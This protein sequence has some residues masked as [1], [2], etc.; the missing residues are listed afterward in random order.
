MI[1]AN[2]L[3][4]ATVSLPISI[5]LEVKLIYMKWEMFND[6]NTLA[7]RNIDLECSLILEEVKLLLFFLIKSSF[8]LISGK[9]S[10]WPN[11]FRVA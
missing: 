4:L 9:I 10:D 3:P 8:S 11:T 2:I 6:N 1:Q 7:V 5:S